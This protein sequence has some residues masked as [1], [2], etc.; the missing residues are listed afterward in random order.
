ME[1]LAVQEM[2]LVRHERPKR[3]SGSKALFRVAEKES[4]Q[5][6]RPSRRVSRVISYCETLLY[7]ML[8]RYYIWVPA[9]ENTLRRFWLKLL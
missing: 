9:E 2:E 8:S 6:H 1:V 4:R 5:V 7:F 3:A